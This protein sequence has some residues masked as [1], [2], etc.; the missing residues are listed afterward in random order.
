M[1]FV[2]QYWSSAP[3]G[4]HG[5]LYSQKAASLLMFCLSYLL[6]LSSSSFN[7]VKCRPLMDQQPLIFHH[8]RSRCSPQATSGQAGLGLQSPSKLPLPL[9]SNGTCTMSTL[10]DQSAER[11]RCTAFAQASPS[12][13]KPKLPPVEGPPTYT[14]TYVLQ[15]R[16]YS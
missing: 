11:A 3:S 13:N 4:H 9:L 7:S 5:S 14:N 2:A 6:Q 8:H 10:D 15:I 16:T 1:E 12:S